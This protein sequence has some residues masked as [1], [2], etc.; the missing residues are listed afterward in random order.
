[1]AE[2]SWLTGLEMLGTRCVLENESAFLWLKHKLTIGQGCGGGSVGWE[3][4]VEHFVLTYFAFTSL[5]FT[6]GMCLQIV[7]CETS[8]VS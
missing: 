8:V 6:P 1:M 5:F 7:F 3:P 2:D 4:T